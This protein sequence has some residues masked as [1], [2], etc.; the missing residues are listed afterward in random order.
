MRAS[1]SRGLATLPHIPPKNEVNMRVVVMECQKV[2]LFKDGKYEKT[3]EPGAYRFWGSKYH[4]EH[5]DLR[6]VMT[7]V[8]GQEVLTKDLVSVRVS[9]SLRFQVV[10]PLKA[11]RASSYYAAEI[12]TFA[13]DAIRVLI[14]NH[15]ISETLERKE[16]FGTLLLDSIKDRVAELGCE[17]LEV[18]VR[19]FGLPGEFKKAFTQ[20]LIAQEEGKAALERA[21]G[22]SAALRNLANAAQLLENRPELALLRSIQAVEKSGGTIVI[23]EQSISGA[24]KP[25]PT[26]DKQV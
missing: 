10:D 21:R 17:L 8:P 6:P 2:L 4:F 11:Y 3:L 7:N 12:Y 25:K 18:G 19:D 15:T 5:F 16:T 24:A 13:H 14:N 1:S 20:V 26:K 22:E 9:L 23:G